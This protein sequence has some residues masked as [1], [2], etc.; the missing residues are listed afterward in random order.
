MTKRLRKLTKNA[1]KAEAAAKLLDE[2]GEI[3]ESLRKMRD[4]APEIDDF[5]LGPLNRLEKGVAS[6]A[7]KAEQVLAAAPKRGKAK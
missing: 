4:L 1:S 6:M 2:L 5:D 7:E 3:E